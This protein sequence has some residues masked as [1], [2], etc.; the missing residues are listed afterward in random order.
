MRA[1]LTISIVAGA[2]LTATAAL[3]ACSSPTTRRGPRGTSIDTF[4]ITARVA[5]NRAAM[6]PTPTPTLHPAFVDALPTSAITKPLD[7]EL[8]RDLRSLGRGYI[9]DNGFYLIRGNTRQM[10]WPV[11][12]TMPLTEQVRQYEAALV[13]NIP[14]LRLPCTDEMLEYAEAM[15]RATSNIS[16]AHRLPGPA[17]SNPYPQLEDYPKRASDSRINRLRSQGYDYIAD[18]GSIITRPS[19]TRAIAYPPSV[20]LTIEQQIARFEFA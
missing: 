10:L 6:T 1:T 16:T 12:T 14:D 3:L 13:A 8:K 4:A 2:S 5:T 19:G 20:P 15:H 18:L 17:L 7:E 11:P 9:A